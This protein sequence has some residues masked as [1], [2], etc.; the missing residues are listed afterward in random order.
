MLGSII[1][2]LGALAGGAL[3]AY[4]AHSANEMSRD[5]AREQMGFQERMSNTSYQRAMQD[6]RQAGLNPILAANLGGASSPS[7]A[8]AGSMQ[9]VLG[10][11]VS[12]AMQMKALM[13]D[14]EKT[15]SEISINKEIQRS[16]RYDNSGKK[17]DA[18]VYSSPLGPLVRTVEKIPL[19]GGALGQYLR[20]SSVFAKPPR[21]SVGY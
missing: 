13:A 20:H 2:G 6:M 7:G 4:G 3:S 11:G 1:S 12:S 10:A 18:D 14:L 9:N 21:K 8:N 15:R 5:I 17:I 16:M 19:I